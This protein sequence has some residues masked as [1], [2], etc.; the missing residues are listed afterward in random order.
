MEHIFSTIARELIDER[1]AAYRKASMTLE[2]EK[3]SLAATVSATGKM[4]CLNLEEWDFNTD[5]GRMMRK[6]PPETGDQ[7][8]SQ[9]S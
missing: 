8:V 1:V 9:Q 3:V 5:T 6:E 4:E 7:P 2:L